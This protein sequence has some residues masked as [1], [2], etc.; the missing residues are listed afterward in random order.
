[1]FVC[2]K[3][4]YL[5]SKLA[6]NRCTDCLWTCGVWALFDQK[7]PGIVVWEELV[8]RTNQIIQSLPGIHACVSNASKEPQR[9][10]KLD[11]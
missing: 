6:S 4:L 5:S 2:P 11:Q 9:L 3:Q 1:M 7:L 10:G 8:S